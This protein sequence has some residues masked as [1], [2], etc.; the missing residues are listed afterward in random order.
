MNHT[1]LSPSVI[2]QYFPNFA[3]V[4]GKIWTN[5]WADFAGILERGR[6][7]IVMHIICNQSIGEYLHKIWCHR[8]D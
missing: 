6:S 8:E 3:E 4:I 2:L 5:I 1:F 7:Q